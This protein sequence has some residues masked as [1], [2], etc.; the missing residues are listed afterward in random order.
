[1]SLEDY[2]PHYILLINTSGEEPVYDV[3]APFLSDIDC[4]AF[5]KRIT[6][7]VDEKGKRAFKLNPA[8]PTHDGEWTEHHVLAVRD[9]TN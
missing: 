8:L 5:L 3:V 6:W 7:T 1:M 4:N 9:Y 2:T